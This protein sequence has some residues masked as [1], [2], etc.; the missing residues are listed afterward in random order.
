MQTFYGTLAS[1]WPLI[2]PV[3][4][5]EGEMREM[6]QLIQS[7]AP[8]ARTLLELGSGGGHNAFHLKKHYALTLTDLSQA[9]LDQ[10]A[11]INSGCEHIAGD[12]RT[13]RLHREFDVVFAHDAID[14]M[15]SEDDLLA[16]FETAFVHLRRG[17]LF[18]CIPDHVREQ[19]EAD[20]DWGGS[21]AA[22]GRSIRFLEWT[23]PVSP[24]AH[25]GVSVYSF[26]AREA[27]GAFHHFVEEH[28]FGLFPEATWKSLLER[29]GFV[30]D[31]VDETGVEEDR[32][33][34]RVFVGVKQAG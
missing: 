19:F 11:A 15:A 32:R 4:G 17:G 9:M 25:T 23:P 8:A 22:D 10:S 24:D 30:V 1:W 27:D 20:T 6:R 33:P 34:R 14:Y 5:S 31:V 21:D 16:A 26:V 2:S 29:V 18:V 12:M 7:R 28:V 3:D 13:M